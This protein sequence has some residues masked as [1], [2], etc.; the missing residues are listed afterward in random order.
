MDNF[1]NVNWG[2]N[3]K[4]MPTEE[5]VSLPE[6]K[7]TS[8]KAYNISKLCGILAMHN[9]GYLWLKTEKSVFC[10]HPGSFVKT[11]LCRNWWAYELLYSIMRPFS[12]S[13]VSKPLY[14][15]ILVRVIEIIPTLYTLRR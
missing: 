3:E 15:S 9:L 14:I 8:I 12:K 5:M 4:M 7:Y 10:T 11:E 1:R 13:I 6:H 2:T